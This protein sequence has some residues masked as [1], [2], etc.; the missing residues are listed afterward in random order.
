MYP[1]TSKW[2]TKQVDYRQIAI[3]IGHIEGNDQPHQ[4]PPDLTSLFIQKLYNEGKC[5]LNHC[6]FVFV[7]SYL[8]CYYCWR[9]IPQ[10]FTVQIYMNNGTHH[11]HI[12]TRWN[13]LI[14]TRWNEL[15]GINS[16]HY[17]YLMKRVVMDCCWLF[18]CKISPN[19]DNL[20][21]KV[22]MGNKGLQAT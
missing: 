20:E 19:D 16:K 4:V 12:W 17:Y 18:I 6:F 10:V 9:C 2:T 11:R 8:V 21:Y 5:T 14:W 3:L 15:A 1:I 13:T 7:F 22:S